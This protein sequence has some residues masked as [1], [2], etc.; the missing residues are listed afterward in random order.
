V[1][2]RYHGCCQA[3]ARDPTTSHP[4]SDV[5][6]SFNL[7]VYLHTSASAVSPFLSL[8]FVCGHSLQLLV[9]LRSFLSVLGKIVLDPLEIRQ[10]CVGPNTSSVLP[11][12]FGKRSMSL[13]CGWNVC[14]GFQQPALGQ[15]CQACGSQLVSLCAP[16]A[17]LPS[18]T[19]QWRGYSLTGSDAGAT[20]FDPLR[21][22]GLQSTEV[23]T[24]NLKRL[25]CLV[26]MHATLIYD[27]CQIALVAV[28]RCTALGS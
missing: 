10:P 13:Y 25:L 20:H 1:S 24:Y 16:P 11:F 7:R 27:D 6:L 26:M 12:T 5:F 8:S 17:V 2:L 3:R 15:F 19:E 28:H 18:S 21:S 22:V 14:E 9:A 4:P 23:S